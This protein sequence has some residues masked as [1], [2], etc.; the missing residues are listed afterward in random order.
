[1]KTEEFNYHLP[2]ELIANYPLE[3][4]SE[5][6]LL[7]FDNNIK[8]RKFFEVKNYFEEGDLLILNETSVIPARLFGKKE[9][10][11]LIEI[12]LER[13]LDDN[14]ILVQI[15]SSRSPKVGSS[16]I[17]N[18][19]KLTVEGR[20]GAFYIL[21]LNQEPLDFFNAYGHVPLPPYIKRADEEL[22]KSRYATVYENK[23]L[24]DSV[25]APTA[26]LH[27]TPDLLEAIKNA[28]AEILKVNLS[29]GAGTFQPV[30]VENIKDHK[31]H[32]EYAHVSDQVVSKILD[33]K[34]KRKKV[35]AVG[36]TVTR[37]LES[38]FFNRN[39][40][41]FKGYTELYITPGYSFKAIDRLITNFHLPKSSLL[42][43]VAAFVGMD[44]MKDLYNHAV[45]NQYRFLSY[46]DAMMINK[47]NV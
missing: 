34:S 30:K 38:A 43:L 33:A 10:G 19:I 15:G 47:K 2:E 22:D 41:E 11:G 18:D 45:K 17:V 16:L 7:V 12:F 46:G 28:G 35:T 27:F 21:K 39:P 1:M 42:M 31:I 44:E 4:R 13:I 36:T 26:G 20:Q 37:A 24:Q 6:K 32:S 25:A 23:N 40:S 3:N 9:T 29:V 8:D 14:K 5:S